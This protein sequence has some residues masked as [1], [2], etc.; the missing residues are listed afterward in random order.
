M[1]MFF[2][3]LGCSDLEWRLDLVGTG[4][5]TR[6]VCERKEE[7]MWLGEKPRT[8]LWEVISSELV[9]DPPDGTPS[10][11][12]G[13]LKGAVEAEELEGCRVNFRAGE[14]DRGVI[15]VEGVSPVEGSEAGTASAIDGDNG[16]MSFFS[17]IEITIFSS[18]SDVMCFSRPL[19]LVKLS[20]EGFRSE[21]PVKVSGSTWGG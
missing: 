5:G 20:I 11:E 14:E 1:N 2:L 12:L 19:L 18:P 8:T 13:L 21:K 6:C 4:V 16:S 7:E 3:S 15:S 9:A 10:F 17:L